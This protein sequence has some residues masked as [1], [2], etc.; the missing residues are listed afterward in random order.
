MVPAKQIS[1]ENK[2]NQGVIEERAEQNVP[3]GLGDCLQIVSVTAVLAQ[4]A[5]WPLCQGGSQGASSSSQT[6][7]WPH[8]VIPGAPHQPK[9]F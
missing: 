7:P 4:E 9:N 8:T 5:M 2:T 3:W 6:P 1:K